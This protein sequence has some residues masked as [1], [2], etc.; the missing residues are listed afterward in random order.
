MIT[1]VIARAA[2]TAERAGDQARRQVEADQSLL[3]AERR[4][5][6]QLEAEAADRRDFLPTRANGNRGNDLHFVRKWKNI[7][8]WW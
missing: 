6:A 5:R 8:P 7:S 1:G 2:L 4:A 3:S